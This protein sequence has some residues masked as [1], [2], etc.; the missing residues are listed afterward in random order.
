MIYGMLVSS[1][2]PQSCL[3]KQ[4]YAL[5]ADPPGESG[6]A[7]ASEWTE[8][9]YLPAPKSNM[10]F[11]KRKAVVLDCEMAG[12]EGGQSVVVLLCAIDFLT[13]EVLV[14][15]LVKPRQPVVDWRSNIS[16]VTPAIMS[17]A[18]AR[19]QALDGW[20]A[21][22]AELWRHINEDTILVGQS[23]NFDLQ[24]LRVVHSKIVD[25][26]ILTAEAVFGQ[27]KEIRRM[28][29]LKALCEDLVGLRIRDSP[30]PHDGLEDALA[31]R[32]LVLWCLRHPAKLKTW[33]IKSRGS[34]WRSK[35]GRR[36]T[37]EPKRKVT[38]K[39]PWEDGGGSDSD[40]DGSAGEVLQ[41]DDVIS[42]DMWPKSP[43]D[44]D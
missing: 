28:W 2:H 7:N 15:S 12:V 33:A 39:A 18:R 21:A 44:S 4:R 43:P 14:N 19:G 27:G 20:Q 3:N 22:R 29:G 38:P 32:E 1:C 10:S 24:A 36:V 26:A 31:A 5:R 13:G 34:F 30:G 17:I 35:A 23:L 37:K 9:E 41:W 42:D 25:S 8:S 11:P 40:D 6:A 16:G